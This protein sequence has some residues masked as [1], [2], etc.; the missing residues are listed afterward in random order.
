[1]VAAVTR[2][3]RNAVICLLYK[4][5]QTAEEIGRTVNLSKQRVGQILKSNGL[6]RSDRR[7]DGPNRAEFLGINVATKVKAAL[8]EE[9]IKRKVS[10][11]ALAS[12]ALSDVL[13]ECGYKL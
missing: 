2:H 5:G 13:S 9:A 10:M 12:E 11:S 1:V 6:A 7:A 8:L 4:A 3:E